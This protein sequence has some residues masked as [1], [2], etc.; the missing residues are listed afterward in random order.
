M[1]P[2][3][4][5]TLLFSLGLIANENDV[6]Y[7]L[8]QALKNKY[9]QISELGQ[10]IAAQEQLIDS[11][12]AELAT[13]SNHVLSNLDEQGKEELDKNIH[14]FL[15][16]MNNHVASAKIPKKFIINELFANKKDNFIK[17]R[18]KS[19]Q[20]R[21]IVENNIWKVMYEDYERLLGELIELDHE[22]EQINNQ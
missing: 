6:S 17:G 10:K 16:T 1:R 3:I 8:T 22:V 21:V 2:L 11:L 13:F 9:V 20:L 5:L 12:I 4:L 19:M 18:I 7:S 14:S 15:E